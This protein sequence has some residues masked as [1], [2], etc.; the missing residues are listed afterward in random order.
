MLGIRKF[1]FIFVYGNPL[2]RGP[3]RK[4]ASSGGCCSRPTSWRSSTSVFVW[5]VYRIHGTG[6]YILPAFTPPKINM[7]PENDGLEDDFPFQ[8]GDFW[9]PC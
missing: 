6:T 2:V 8:L 3:E 7:E 9:V 5:M 1:P 4:K